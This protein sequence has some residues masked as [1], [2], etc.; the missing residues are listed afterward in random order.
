[1]HALELFRAIASGEIYARAALIVSRHILKDLRL[2]TPDRVL[3]NRSDVSIALCIAQFKLHEA[4]WLR[5]GERLQQNC[6]DDREYGSVRADAQSQCSDGCRRKARAAAQHAE[7]VAYILQQIFK[8]LRV[9]QFGLLDHAATR[10]VP[11]L[12]ATAAPPATGWPS[13][14]QPSAS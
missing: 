8:E 1:M 5:I 4:I 3:R 13:T 2:F 10:N 9:L 6:V 14:I 12:A 7:R 11:P